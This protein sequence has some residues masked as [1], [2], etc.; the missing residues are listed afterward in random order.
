MPGADVHLGPFSAGLNNVSEI[1]TIPDNA[2]SDV[3]NFE[4]D[5]DGSLV[6]R[7]A[8]IPEQTTGVVTGDMNMLGYCVRASDGE[9]FLVVA[10]TGGNTR[11][12]QLSTQTWTVIWS[13]QA[14]GFAQYNNTIV[15]TSATATGGYWDMGANTFT[16]TPLMPVAAGIVFYQERFWA[17]GVQGTANA[18]TMWYSNLNVISPPQSIYDWAITSNFITVSR[19]DGQWITALV[20]DINALLVFRSGSTWQFTYPS[21]VASGTL[22]VLSP[23]I[24][25]EN[26]YCIVNYENY[27]LLFSAGFLYQFINYK[28]YPLNT[29]KVNFQR[30]TLGNSLQ[31]NVRVSMFARR[32]VVWYYGATF[33]YSVVTSTWTRW[34]SPTTNAGH[35]WMIPASSTTGDHRIALAVTGEN[36]PAK[37]QLWRIT[38]GVLTTLVGEQM[39]CSIRTK[40]YAMNQYGKYKRLTY[41]SAEV[42]SAS[43]VTGNAHPVALSTLSVTWD[44]MA[45]TTW[46]VLNAGSWDNPLIAPI[47]Y[48]DVTPFPALTPQDIVVKLRQGFRFLRSYYE[49]SMMCDGTSR[50]S[51]A[52]IYG[53]TLE[54]KIHAPVSEKVS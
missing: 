17:W 51:P 43:G 4:F 52:R 28:W 54:V 7:P 15:M 30:A 46:D 6:N 23:T 1:G 26:Q 45:A 11:L 2:L 5:I 25:A 42:R 40:A 50:T 8:I 18:T 20:A 14:S 16:A 27:Y 49:L 9:T 3:S 33:V 53:I 29:K 36:D 31:F 37:K 19:G 24:G 39:A 10:F 22:R 13:G 48:T 32:A 12:Y 44:Q 35:F 47:V 21:A 34:D 38:D 41:W